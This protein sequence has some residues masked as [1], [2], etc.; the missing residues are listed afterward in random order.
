MLHL[1]LGAKMAAFAGYEM[2]M[3]YPKGIIYEHLHCRSHAGFF[4]ISHMGQCLVLGYEASGELERLTPSDISGLKLGH[5]KYTVL[6]NEDGGIIDDIIVTRSE[7]GLMIVVNAACKDKDF[8]YLASQLSDQC[9]FVELPDQALFAIQGPAASTIMRKFSVTAVNLAFMATCE[10]ALGGIKCTISRSGYTGEDG[11]EI[12]VAKSHAE[13]LARLFL[14]EKDVL[15][16]GLGARDTLRLE[17]GLC[18]YGHELND[19]ITP[20]EAG[21][22]WLIKK[23]RTDFPGADHINR[24][25]QQGPDKIR[26]GLIVDSKQPVREG[27]TICNTNGEVIGHITSGSFSP[28]LGKPIAMAMLDRNHTDVGI[29]L[30][31]KVRDHQV[32]VIVTQ[33]PFIPHRYKR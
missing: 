28:S 4:D 20:V 22:H 17:A 9:E 24:Q 3:S 10:A 13:A 30:Y 16:I 7:A 26:V 5:Q 2:P 1:E 18:L 27:S 31:A 23:G 21:L 6:T 8:N 33:L 15:P 29:R 19:T 14:A 12:S 25:L 11:F 32:P